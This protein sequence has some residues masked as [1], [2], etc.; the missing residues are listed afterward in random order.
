MKKFLLYTLLIFALPLSA[1]VLTSPL[2]AMKYAYGEDSIVSKKNILLSKKRALLIQKDARVKLDSKIFRTFKATKENKT[3]GFGVLINKKVRSKNAVVLYLISNEGIL[4]NIEIIAFNEPKEYL[5][6][7][8]WIS[9]FEDI[10]VSTRLRVS[11]DIPT[12]TGATLSAS[13]ITEGSRVAFA[14]YSE[15]LKEK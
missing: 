15:V 9:Q 6:S 1:K 12:I 11:K 3:L 14:L 13:S 10:A 5:P 4:K 7:K 2:D 8:K